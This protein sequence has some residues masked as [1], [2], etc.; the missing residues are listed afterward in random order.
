MEEDRPRNKG[1]ETFVAA[2]LILVFGGTLFFFL[3]I[4]TLGMLN[5]VVIAA[6]AITTVGY[7]HYL[8]WGQALT[9]ETAGEREEEEL[10]Q[11]DQ[12]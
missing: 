9:Q 4:A 11:A 2:L 1:R 3:N 5:Y 12:D 7:V 6:V 8:L 10:S